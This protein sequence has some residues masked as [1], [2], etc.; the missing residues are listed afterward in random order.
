VVPERRR[1]GK[2]ISADRVR[3]EETSHTAGA[4]E[5]NL[6]AIKTRTGNFG[7]VL[8]KTCLLKQ[9]IE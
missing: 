3:N 2:T 8:R 9:V 4:E 1:L 5:K 7:H 6:R